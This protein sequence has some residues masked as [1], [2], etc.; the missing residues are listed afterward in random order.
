[1]TR[2]AFLRTS[3]AGRGRIG[4]TLRVA[5]CLLLAVVMLARALVPTGF[6]PERDAR[7][8]EIIVTMCSGKTEPQT[9]H[10]RLPGDAPTK[11]TEQRDCPYAVGVTST[12]SRSPSLPAPTH[13]QYPH[14]YPPALAASPAATNWRPSAPP[15]GPPAFA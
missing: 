15:T 8:G 13:V 11:D 10:V 7:T 1:V 14:V 2:N 6:M 5:S 12:A 4:E 9:I 3:R